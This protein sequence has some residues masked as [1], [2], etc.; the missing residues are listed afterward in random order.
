MTQ[1]DGHLKRITLEAKLLLLLYPHT[2]SEELMTVEDVIT[3]G[4]MAREFRI[5]RNNISRSLSE[6]TGRGAV[7]SKTKHIKGLQRRRKAYFLTDSGIREAENVIREISSRLVSVRTLEGDILEWTLERTRKELSTLLHRDV[8]HH[9]LVSRYLDGG[10]C[11]LGSLRKD[12]CSSLPGNI[13]DVERIFGREREISAVK[14]AIENDVNLISVLGMAGIGKTTLVSSA[15]RDIQGP[16]IWRD[17]DPW[18]SPDILL[19]DLTSSFSPGTPRQG[20]DMY[21]RARTLSR[22]LSSS[23]TV[24]ILDDVH[25]CGREMNQ[26]LTILS[27][28]SR[29]DGWTLILI[30]RVRPPYYS[31]TEAVSSKEIMEITLSGIE[32]EPSFRLME[33]LS[34]P[35]DEMDEIFRT[36]EGHPLAISICSID[37]TADPGAVMNS[38]KDFLR[39]KVLSELSERERDLMELLAVF[40]LP[41]EP[42]KLSFEGVN[43]TVSSLLDRSIIITYPD[44][45]VDLHDSIREGIRETMSE[46][47]FRSLRERVREHYRKGSSDT[48][49][50]QFLL[51]TSELSGGNELLEHLLDHGD[52]LVGRGFIP[53]A[54]L[55]LEKGLDP[56]DV[57][58]E[59]RLEV[60]RYDSSLLLNR[61]EEALKHLRIAGSRAEEL[62]RTSRD[63]KSL[64]LSVMVLNRLAERAMREGLYRDVIKKLGKGLEIARDSGARDQ[65]AR[66][67]SNMGTAYLDL[68]DPETAIRFFQDSLEL[69][70]EIGD[71]RGE[72][73]TR[74]NMGGALSRAGQLSIALRQY[75]E[76]IRTSKKV[77]LLRIS[78]QASFRVG[79]LYRFVNDRKEAIH[80]MGESALGYARIGDMDYSLMVLTDLME[81]ST[82]ERYLPELK[83]TV[84]R[85]IRTVEGGGFGMIRRLFRARESQTGSIED[86]LHL[87]RDSLNGERIQKNRIKMIL[88]DEDARNSMI[89]KSLLKR[90]L[91]QNGGSLDP[92]IKSILR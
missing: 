16:L 15:M 53:M 58:Q 3:Q 9:E 14:K 49:M 46:G 20:R 57:E 34:V 26:L 67:L 47:I 12:T 66:M 80:F 64:E 7:R 54:R 24:M 84:E 92:G 87:I 1:R 38:F 63:R 23:H 71:N 82:E 76:C 79:K 35:E 77:D 29:K 51:L 68:G 25:R 18:M 89:R 83:L 36:T 40:D 48:D 37:P 11:D 90:T 74:L 43:P 62:L 19:D 81:I 17:L 5:R 69:F 56:G 30:S 88:K 27:E 28:L 60:L 39:E 75:L 55:S 2:G 4:G 52:Y 44:G 50:V 91:L 22:S 73:V 33:D 8:P 61:K 41:V 13:P 86:L 10:L 78:S 72:A 59:V 70:L 45:S 32:R 31:R 42:R 21:R 6:L 85:L 65:E